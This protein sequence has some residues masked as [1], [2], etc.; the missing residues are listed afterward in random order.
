MSRVAV[1]GSG[2][3]GM[4]AAYFLSR[5]HTVFLF[6]KDSRLGGHTH[7]HVVDSSAGPIPVDTGFIVHN[8]RT[9]PN[10]IRLFRELNVA[11]IPSDMSFAVFQPSTG[12]EYSSRGLNGFFARRSHLLNPSHYALLA[13][14][15]R[16]NA[17]APKLLEDPGAESLT[18]GDFWKREGFSNR[19]RDRYLV[20]M[21]SA[22]WSMDRDAMM[23]FPAFTLVRFFHNHGMLGINTHPQWYTLKGGCSSYIEPVTRPYA[24]R[25]TMG[26]NITA[27]RRGPQSV[28]LEFAGRP[29]QHFDQVVLA[30]HGPQALA[31][32]ADATDREREILGAFRTSRNVAVLHTDESLLP[33]RAP[34]RASWNYNVDGREGATLTYSMNRLQSLPCREQICVTLNDGGQVDE[35]KV[36]RRIVY[37]HPIYD[38]AAVAAQVRWSEISGENRTHFCGAYWFYGFHEDGLRSAL[39]VAESLGAGWQHSGASEAA[40]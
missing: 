39:R 32:L 20:P 38:R 22:I 8:D 2:I 17:T 40:A 15:V 13:E 27:V 23:R 30:C 7:T 24:D 37:H 19:L 28:T 1:I 10:L 34:A 29:A 31:L 18:L 12:F 33:R 35:R 3:A 36:L 9:Y 16:F 25:I 5:K 14:I 11:R 6:E 4:S 21:A 26:V